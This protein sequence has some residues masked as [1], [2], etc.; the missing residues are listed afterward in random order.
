MRKLSLVGQD[1][2]EFIDCSDV[3]PEPEGLSVN[4]ERR[5]WLGRGDKSSDEPDSG[6]H[7]PVGKAMDDLERTV[8]LMNGYLHRV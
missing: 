6:P 1:E 3:I 4:K 8:S 7:L 2:S 5:G